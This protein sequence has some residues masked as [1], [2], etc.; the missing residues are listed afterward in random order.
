[1]IK[2][3]SNKLGMLAMGMAM[4][5]TAACSNSGSESGTNDQGKPVSA[6]GKTVVNFS[7]RESSSFFEAAEKRFEEKYPDIDLQIQAVKKAEEDWKPGDY[8]KYTK[9]TNTELLSG[10]GADILEVAEL[11]FESYASKKLIA[12]MNELLKQDTSLS[13]VDLQAK[14]E[15]FKTDGD[16]YAIPFGY[17]MR[18]FIGDGNLLAD[19]SIDDSR[20]TWAEFA[21]VAKGLMCKESESGMDRRYALANEPPDL[22]LWEIVVDGYANFVDVSG[23]KASFDSPKFVAAMQQVKK[24]YDDSI[25]TA[26]PAEVG[27][28]LFYST[29]LSS[30]GNLIDEIHYYFANPKLIGKP[31]AGTVG[32]RLAP[33]VQLAIR[34]NSP[35]KDEA[36]KFISFLL[37]EEVQSMK[38]REDYGFSML[39]SVNEKELRDVQ[40]QV[41]AGTYK[42]PSGKKPQVSAEQFAQ[43]EQFM[44]SAGYFTRIDGKVVRMIGDES[45]AFFSGQKSADEVAKLIQN[46][47]TTYLNE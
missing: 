41:N 15:V 26:E 32:T 7:V 13:G 29:V 42:L 1:M 43:Y 3:K 36:W 17:F 11:P 5:A 12:N 4:L 46:R 39:D 25:A 22:I 40:K 27:R 37:S 33:S 47:A 38:E 10:K 20:W 45:P 34:D 14:L 2:M 31:Q 23:K 21:E 44:R 9:T 8:E 28:Q 24:M 19:E 30:P 35:V 18:G 16:L 6:E